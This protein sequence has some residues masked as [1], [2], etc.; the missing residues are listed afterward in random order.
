MLGLQ[1][2][3]DILLIWILPKG[4]G[5]FFSIWKYLFIVYYV[6]DTVLSTFRDKESI[7]SL[8]PRVLGS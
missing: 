3:D 8:S 5:G 4:C 2:N 1:I 7:Q 6:H